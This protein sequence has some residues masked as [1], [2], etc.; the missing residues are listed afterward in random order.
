MNRFMFSDK[1]IEAMHDKKP[2]V[3]L[4]SAVI[5]YG[6]PR[7]HNLQVAERCEQV[8]EEAGA[9]PVTIGIIKGVIQV[10]LNKTHFEELSSQ[11]NCMKVNLSNIAVA[12]TKAKNGA[13]TV[14]ATMY[15]AHEIGIQVMS[16]GGIGGVH[17]SPG[18]R[19][20]ISSDMTA[21][22]RFPVILV[23]SGPKSLLDIAATRELLETMGIPIIGYKTNK[24]PAF[25]LRETDLSVDV[26]VESAAE[27]AAIAEQHRAMGFTTAVLVCQP[28][29]ED[30]A[31]EPSVLEP[32]LAKA[33]RA[34]SRH[35]ISERD[36]TPFVLEQLIELT[37]GASLR[38]NIVLL[39]NNARLAAEIAAVLKHS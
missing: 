13:T 37:E 24:L 7:P 20:D 1:V 28:A 27:A 39:E 35:K 34:A 36:R 38:A 26:R 11:K 30:V 19:L 2:L 17:P 12:M 18:K 16:T 6:L 31:L 25:Y 33:E 32:A 22:A 3:A 14:S 29:P 8:I 9:F 21:L 5:S 10:G 23:C 15:T 4:E